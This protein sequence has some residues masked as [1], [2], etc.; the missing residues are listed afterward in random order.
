MAGLDDV[1][2]VFH[3]PVVGV[4]GAP[5]RLLQPPNG[6]AVASRLRV[7]GEGP[8]P[9]LAGAHRLAQEPLGGLCIPGLRQVEVD[10]VATAV[11]RAMQTRPFPFDPYACF[12]HAPG[13]RQ[14]AWP[15]VPAQPPFDL[16][17]TGLHPAMDVAWSTETP[18][19]SSISSRSRQLTP[20]RQCHR[21]AQR[22][23]SPR[24]WRDLKSWIMGGL[25]WH[26]C[27]ESM[28][29]TSLSVS[30]WKSGASKDQ[31]GPRGQGCMRVR[32]LRLTVAGRAAREAER[33]RQAVRAKARQFHGC[34]V[35]AHG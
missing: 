11:D 12:V 21:T 1:V 9:L 25:R 24:K 28:L 27:R 15:K 20:Y 14:A 5:A 17:R 19:S 13:S 30:Q 32:Q 34:A 16:R 3:L 26:A 23:I 22:M 2:E 10:G 8:L 18:R 7:D 35:H 29:A 31:P 4:R 6:L 33:R